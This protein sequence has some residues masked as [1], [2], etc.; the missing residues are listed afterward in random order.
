MSSSA[1]HLEARDQW[2]G[3]NWDTRRKVSSAV[4]LWETAGCRAGWSRLPQQRP[5]IPPK[6]SPNAS[7]ERSPK[8]RAIIA[9]SSIRTGMR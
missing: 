9:S 4:R 2:I 6:R 7:T 8:C 1:L 5:W 3:W